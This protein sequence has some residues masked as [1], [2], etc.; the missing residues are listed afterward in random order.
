M[1]IHCCISHFSVEIY[2]GSGW[3][4]VFVSAIVCLF[5]HQSKQSCIYVFLPLS[6]IFLLDFG[7]VLA[8]YFVFLFLFMILML[9]YNY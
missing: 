3:C 1:A 8:M 7:T 6:K 9:H 2:Q 5:S 4:G